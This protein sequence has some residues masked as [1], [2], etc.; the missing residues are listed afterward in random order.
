MRCSVKY[1][2]YVPTAVFIS[3]DRV[4]ELVLSFAMTFRLSHPKTV[5][6]LDTA[7]FAS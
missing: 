5:Y 3:T 4:L 1:R 7:P 6:L 2:L